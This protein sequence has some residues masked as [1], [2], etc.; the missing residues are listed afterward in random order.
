MNDD[1]IEGKAEATP[2]TA[3]ELIAQASDTEVLVREETLP[4]VF[5]DEETVALAI[6]AVRKEVEHTP[7]DLSTRKGREAVA[8]IAAKPRRFKA[9]VTKFIKGMTDGHYAEIKRLNGLRDTFNDAMTGIAEAARK[10]LD[11]WESREKMRVDA[12]KEKLAALKSTALGDTLEAVGEQI[13]EF[14]EM[15]IEAEEWEEFT[16]DATNERNA[17]LVRL[18]ER[19]DYLEREAKLEAERKAA[20]ERLAAEAQKAEEER[21][22]REAKLEAE[23]KAEEERA[24]KAEE[25][26][27]AAQAELAAAQAELAELRAAQAAKAEEEAKAEN[28]EDPQEG[29]TATSASKE[30]EQ[31]PSAGEAP[32]EDG[33]EEEG[34]TGSSPSAPVQTP[35]PSNISPENETWRA[36]R[37]IGL[38]ADQADTL[39]DMVKSGAIPNVSWTPLAMAAE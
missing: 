4:M 17:L 24:Q 37:G 3:K 2:E 35:P 1:I 20:A 18:M 36:L 10:P 19:K 32:G 23:R 7:V 8:S 25:E 16:D 29:D 11:D 33:G 21:K 13:T 26:A 30:P 34:E 27:K 38:A 15:V 9:P 39:I 12:L 6:A 5:S 31:T 28:T 14:R 22:E